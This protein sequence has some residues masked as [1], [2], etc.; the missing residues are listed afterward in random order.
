MNHRFYRH[1]L[2]TDE[3]RC[4]PWEKIGEEE[5]IG[6]RV[7]RPATNLGTGRGRFFPLLQR[8]AKCVEEGESIC[9]FGA[10]PGT[11]LRI[12]RQL[13]GG[14]HVCLGA[15]GFGFSPDFR[16]ALRTLRVSLVECEFDVRCPPDASTP[17]LLG[18]PV[19]SRD[20]QWD[21]AVCSEVIEH[22]FQPL[23][24]LMGIAR[25]LRPEGRL[26]LTTNSASFIGDVLKLLVGRHN[27]ESLE[28]SHVLTDSLWR[29]HIRL[30]LLPELIQLLTLC[31]FETVEGFYFDNSSVY[32]GMKGAS[33]R[34]FRAITGIVPHWRS[35]QFITAVK[36]GEPSPVAIEAIDRSFVTHGMTTLT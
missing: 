12:A 17:H 8:I 15:T 34:A 13:P 14:E 2:Q 24:L 33:L 29:P 22:Q 23:S 11:L 6:R 25:M 10:F 3:S 26:Y 16:A 35:H 28:R 4:F 18:L 19:P 7:A 36:T 30:F 9:D 20:E 31:G 5:R 21:V 27:V 32:T 1:L